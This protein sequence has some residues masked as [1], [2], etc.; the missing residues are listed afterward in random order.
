MTPK[1]FDKILLRDGG[2]CVHCGTTE[3]LVPHHRM[4]RGMGGSQA[5]ETPSNVLTMCSRFNAAMEAENS[6]QLWAIQ[7][8]W[9]LV[10]VN[11]NMTREILHHAAVWDHTWSKWYLLDDDYNRR[12]VSRDYG[13]D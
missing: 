3:G 6:A 5:L 12:E 9:K 10:R 7:N 1:E 2:R 11:P 8:G 13:K 4:N